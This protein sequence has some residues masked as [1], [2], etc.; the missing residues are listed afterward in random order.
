M[1][2]TTTRDD[3]KPIED[4]KEIEVEPGGPGD[5]RRTPRRGLDVLS[6]VRTVI[7]Y[8]GIYPFMLTALGI[9]AVNRRLE[10]GLD[11]MLSTYPDFALAAGG[12]RTRVTGEEH[13]WTDRP[14]VF[15]FNHRN[16][17]DGLIVAR[18]LQHDYTSVAKEEMAKAPLI[19]TVGRR[20]GIVF[21]N[22]SDSEKAVASLQRATAAF[23]QGKSVILAPEGTRQDETRLGPFKK[24]AFRMAMAGGVP[25][26]P[27]V[28]H[29]AE[30][31][32]LASGFLMKSGV[33]DVDV[34]AP[35]S[36]S[37]WTVD[38]LDERIAEVHRA[39]LDVLER[40]PAHSS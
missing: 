5:V 13:L 8:G 35:I 38:D 24:G 17:I 30:A 15:I 29:N 14:A 31:I 3:A 32:Q 21:I 23:D 6:V 7:G 19:G 34:L 37:D 16:M 1:A 39:F 40:G 9:G 12:V 11:F 18:L 36:V 4:A 22:R 28:F 26:V 25:V 2:T 33:V 20:A 10:T 27:I